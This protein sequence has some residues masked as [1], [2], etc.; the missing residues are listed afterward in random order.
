[1]RIILL[2]I[3]GTACIIVVIMVIDIL[4]V[5]VISDTASWNWLG[6]S[7]GVLAGLYLRYTIITKLDLILK[8]IRHDQGGPC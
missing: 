4:F 5:T 2:L 1:M 3:G 7:I 6:S 8:E